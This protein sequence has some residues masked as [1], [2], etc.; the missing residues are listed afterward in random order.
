MSVDA[1]SDRKEKPV[2]LAY[3]LIGA[4]ATGKSRLALKLAETLGVEVISADSMNVYRGMDIGTSKPEMAER[5][6]V[7]HHGLDIRS[8]AERCSVGTWLSD[9]SECLRERERVGDMRP[10][11]VAGGTGLYVKCLLQGLAPMPEISTQVRMH[12]ESIADS[13]TGLEDLQRALKECNPSWFASLPDKSNKRRLQRALELASSGLTSPPATWEQARQGQ[14]TRPTG[15]RMDRTMLTQRIEERARA[16]FRDGLVEEA[17]GLLERYP[18]MSDTA[19]KAIGYA[20]AFALVR[21][22]I[23]ASDA[24]E[25]T[26][27]RT[28]RLAKRQRTWFEHQLDVDC[29][30]VECQ[31][32]DTV[33][34]SILAKWRREGPSPLALTVDR[35]A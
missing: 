15:L 6:R 17:A 30:D 16:M 32:L 5:H 1:L 12:W 14:G 11:I 13:E 26:N 19:L 22:E 21:G 23:S 28:R 35:S 4:T 10:L 7:R 3:F 27:V 20:E 33:H 18:S 34:D 8:P 24:I 9:V 2:H 25:K 31:A 29:V